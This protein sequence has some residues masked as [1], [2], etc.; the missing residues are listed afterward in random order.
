MGYARRASALLM[1]CLVPSA[2]QAQNFRLKADCI[3]EMGGGLYGIVVLD[4]EEWLKLW[5]RQRWRAELRQWVRVT[6]ECSDAYLCSYTRGL[7]E[8]VPGPVFG[9][10]RSGWDCTREAYDRYG[11]CRLWVMTTNPP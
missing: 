5:V 9:R 4:R 2:S 6:G 7:S 1:L 10:H 8:P 3:C 11:F